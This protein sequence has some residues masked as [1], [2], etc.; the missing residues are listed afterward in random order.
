[1]YTLEQLLQ[2]TAAKRARVQS[3]EGGDG[4]DYSGVWNSY[5]KYLV[6]CL[7]QRRG[8]QLG[9]FCKIGWQ[10][11]KKAVQGGQPP[12]C[13]PF[14][15]LTEQFARTYCPQEVG[16]LKQPTGMYELCPMEDFNFSK[17][18][19]KYSN[20]LTKDNVFTGLRAL[21]QQ[22]GEAISDGKE[23]DIS[24]PGLGRFLVK[25][26]EPRFNFSGD[27]NRLAEGTE[28]IVMEDS[29]SGG[30]QRPPAAPSF[31]KKAPEEAL[32][33]GIQGGGASQY[34]PQLEMQAPSTPEYNYNEEPPPR[35]EIRSPPE[36]NIDM[37]RRTPALTS[38][39][40]KKEVA[41]KEAMDRHISEMEARA[42]EAVREKEAWHGH[43]N[44]CLLQ[45]RDEIQVK[46]S[47]AQQNQY[48][49]RQQVQWREKQK[50]EQRKDEIIAASAHDFPKFTEPAEEEMKDFLSG[51]HARMRA[52]LD[53]QVKTNNTLRNLQKRRER[54]I[55]VDQ[56]EANRMEMAM[57]RE[58]ERAKK[59]Y[60]KEA[61]ATAW[62]SEIR[63]KN[64][65]KAIES[66]NKVGS[67]ASS[68]APQVMSMDQIPPS[69]AGST[70]S[71]AGRVM[72]GS[73]RR[74]PLGASSSLSKL[75]R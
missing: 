35:S 46:R 49:L 28:P 59:A 30:Y 56:L 24:F 19:I 52:D 31:S 54:S 32:S 41:Y 3:K 48:F 21:V 13:S 6:S 29:S 47:R 69:R 42:S 33:L 5:I 72:T 64:I 11:E 45:E 2:D 58:A 37:N 44:D 62:N 40:Y 51:Q 4:I 57:L 61:L 53:E 12:K 16:K 73:S 60:D 63:M 39:Q 18:A 75:Q 55:E 20:Q 34:V 22:L 7:E 65:W 66:H 8:L 23:C 50:K 15:Q 43:V 10:M 67:H 1:M 27:V 25:D 26:R 71:N 36:S 68:H 38:Q 9:T 14:F 70:M 17:A 74:V